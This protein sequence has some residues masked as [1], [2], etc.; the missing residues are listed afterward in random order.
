MISVIHTPVDV[1]VEE[2]DHPI[3]ADAWDVSLDWQAVADAFAAASRQLGWD[4]DLRICPERRLVEAV[5]PVDRTDHVAQTTLDVYAA[6]ANRIG[7][8]A[9]TSLWVDFDIK[10]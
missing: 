3:S 1:Q 4:A 9:F 7:V 2:E 5:V 8:D 10:P 6:V